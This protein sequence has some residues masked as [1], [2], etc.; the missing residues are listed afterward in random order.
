MQLDK[1]QIEQLYAFTRQ[2][3]VEWY[4]LQSELVDHLANAIEVEWQQNPKHTFEEVLDI[5]F[6]KFGIFGFMDVVEERQKFLYRKYAR[7]IWNYYKEFFRLPKIIFTFVSI[8]VLFLFSGLF[9]NP[10]YFFL[11]ILVIGITFVITNLV[12][13]TREYKKREKATGKKWLFEEV[14]KNFNSFPIMF[15]PVNIF[16][17]VNSFSQDNSWTETYSLVSASLFVLAGIWMFVQLKVVPKN[18]SEELEK[19]YSEYQI[20]K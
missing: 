6:K 16:N 20:S 12:K 10:K 9:S 14:A 1:Q 3:Y 5:E 4:D 11:A 18:V 15:L 19:T 8:Y 2:H 17:M 13:T 7:L